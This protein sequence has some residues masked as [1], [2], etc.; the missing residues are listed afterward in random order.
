VY[1]N[2]KEIEGRIREVLENTE[3]ERG[4]E[5]KRRGWWE[6][7][8]IYGKEVEDEKGIEGIEER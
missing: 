4:K 7:Y 5:R 8:R 3:M 2:L 6:K 1:E